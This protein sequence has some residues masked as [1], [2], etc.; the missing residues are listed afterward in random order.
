MSGD[1]GGVSGLPHDGPHPSHRDNDQDCDQGEPGACHDGADT[2]TSHMVSEAVTTKI[3]FPRSGTNVKYK[4]VPC[5]VNTLIEYC[6]NVQ[7]KIISDL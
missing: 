3:D 1:G 4:C 7:Y 6:K 5:K 2:L